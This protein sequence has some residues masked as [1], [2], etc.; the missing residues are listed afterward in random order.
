MTTVAAVMRGKMT[1]TDDVRALMDLRSASLV[2][3]RAA[4]AA[5]YP[6]LGEG[7]Q[8]TSL[9]RSYHARAKE[10]IRCGA[11]C[12]DVAMDWTILVTDNLDRDSDF[13]RSASWLIDQIRLHPGELLVHQ[14]A[15]QNRA[16]DI[17]R[18]PTS[19]F[20]VLLLQ[21][22]SKRDQNEH[23]DFWGTGIALTESPRGRVSQSGH[24]IVLRPLALELSRSLASLHDSEGRRGLFIGNTAVMA[25]FDSLSVEERFHFWAATRHLGYPIGDNDEGVVAE[26]QRRREAMIPELIRA[27]G[28]LRSYNTLLARWQQNPAEFFAERD[29]RGTVGSVPGGVSINFG[30][31]KRIE[32]AKTALRQLIGAAQTDLLMVNNPT[33]QQAAATAAS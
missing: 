26:L 10:Q 33:L 21:D 17:G 18:I 12:G 2:E 24:S 15:M 20:P 28:V 5:G 14:R 27:E 7:S 23:E 25:L 4:S 19:N 1:E 16:W 13:Y 6:K 32:G 3:A 8:W 31:G 11:T 9:A 22:G 29:N 30:L